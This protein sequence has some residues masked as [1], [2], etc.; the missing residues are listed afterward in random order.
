MIL[1]NVQI[2]AIL[3]DNPNKGVVEYA[4]K[5]RKDLFVH[6]FGDG[7]DD[8]IKQINSFENE[9]QHQARK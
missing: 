8:Y 3:Q 5:T 1:T 4:Q 7:L 6:V 9:Y 2:A